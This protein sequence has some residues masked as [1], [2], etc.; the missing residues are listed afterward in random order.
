ML[1][2]ECSLG[3]T[4]LDSLQ[5]SGWLA[6]EAGLLLKHGELSIFA[7]L[8]VYSLRL[9]VLDYSIHVLREL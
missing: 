4:L 8:D 5:A 7:L 1:R 2:E 9:L 3:Y 6:N